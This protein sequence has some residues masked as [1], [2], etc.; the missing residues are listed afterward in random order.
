MSS[1]SF[2]Q[3]QGS[4]HSQELSLPSTT[5]SMSQLTDQKSSVQSTAQSTSAA[6]I[7]DYQAKHH[8]KQ[9]F[10]ARNMSWDAGALYSS[11][12]EEH[13]IPMNQQDKKKSNS[14]CVMEKQE[15]TEAALGNKTKHFLHWINPK[16]KGQG[17]KESI[18]SKDETVAKTITKNVEKSPPLTKGPMKP[19][20]LKKTEE[21]GMTFFDACQ[22][23]D[24]EQHQHPL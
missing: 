14:K 21:E 24:N 5:P 16:V 1:T 7:Q 12:L 15:A 23:I 18:L 19:A 2:G 20:K 6:T 3:N 17:H 11:S 8:R 9:E 13:R 10:Q 22:C 4:H